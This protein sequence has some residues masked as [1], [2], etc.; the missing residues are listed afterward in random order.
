MKSSVNISELWIHACICMKL[1]L[2][3]YSEVKSTPKSVNNY[4][5]LYRLMANISLS[6][7]SLIEIQK[8]L[9]TAG[10]TWRY[11]GLPL[12]VC[13]TD[14]DFIFSKFSFYPMPNYHLIKCTFTSTFFSKI[15]SESTCK[16]WVSVLS[17]VQICFEL[18]R[19]T[20]KKWFV[21]SLP[22]SIMMNKWELSKGEILT[23]TCYS[24]Y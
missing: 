17:E 21:C 11:L 18:L 16:P 12:R 19:K 10:M 8:F 14:S 23:M 5:F 7:V 4:L 9:Q 3:F 1:S 15:F 24:K 13:K 6:V 22:S 2:A 20:L